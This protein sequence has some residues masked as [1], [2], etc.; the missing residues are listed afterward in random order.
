[1]LNPNWS[2]DFATSHLL[3]HQ[4]VIAEAVIRAL[5]D[6][7]YGGGCQAFWRPAD[8]L[9]NGHPYGKHS[10]LILCHDG[11]DLARFCNHDY[12]SYEDMERLRD[13]LHKI[14]LYVE[15]CTSTYSAVYVI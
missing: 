1:M 9:A 6:D 10:L 4:Q 2:K 7:A 13:E 8:W 14:G 3:P 12:Q 15:Q 5:P 11:G